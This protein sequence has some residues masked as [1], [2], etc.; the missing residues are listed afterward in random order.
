MGTILVLPMIAIVIGLYLIT[1]GLWE[2]RY[3]VNRSRYITF[4]FT[5]LFLVFVVSVI[6]IFGSATFHVR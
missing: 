6:L 1:L 2:L 5:G 4:M 3:G